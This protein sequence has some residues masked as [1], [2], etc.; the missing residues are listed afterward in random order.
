MSIDGVASYADIYSDNL[1][2]EDIKNVDNLG[3]EW[4]GRNIYDIRDDVCIKMI[5]IFSRIYAQ[6]AFTNPD[7]LPQLKAEIVQVFEDLFDT[8]LE[9]EEEPSP[10]LYR[11]DPI[12]G[13]Y[14]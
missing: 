1:T 6:T 2:D 8:K 14:R 9:D 5:G 7:E 3:V 12:S 10:L 11:F 4:R 13:T